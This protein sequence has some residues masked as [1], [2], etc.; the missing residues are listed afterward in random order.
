[1]LIYNLERIYKA[2]GIDNPYNLFATKGF[3]SSYA[4]KLAKGKVSGMKLST[5]ER[6]CKILNCTP[7][8][9]LEWIPEKKSEISSNHPLK[10]LIGSDDQ[11]DMSDVM[12]NLPLEKISK[13][14]DL[15]FSDPET[16]E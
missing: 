13:I 10:A 14:K 5:L 4:S 6:V 7:N 8:D 16:K 3:S 1:M 12:K 2:R 15:I 11:I 9:L